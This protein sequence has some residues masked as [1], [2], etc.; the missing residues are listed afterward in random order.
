MRVVLS[1]ISKFHTFD[2]AREMDRN[3]VLVRLFTG[4][5]KWKLRGEDLPMQKVSTFPY[6]QTVW[7]ALGRFGWDRYPGK[8][9]LNWQCHK[10]LDSYVARHLPPCDVFHALSYSGL[11]SGRAAQRTGAAWV[12]DS[13]TWHWPYLED[14]M[15][16]EF[17]RVGLPYVGAQQRFVDY[18]VA[19][20][21]GA[22]AITVPSRR[23]NETFLARGVPAS[24]MAV[25]PYGADL[26][27]FAPT[28]E[29]RFDRF[30]VL[31]VGQVIV[32]KGI[33]DLLEGFR[34][35]ALPNSELLIVGPIWADGRAILARRS[36]P[37]V[38]VI[39]AVP[40][41]A[42]ADYYSSSDVMVLPS[43]CEG[44]ALVIGQALACGCP[45]IATPATGAEDLFTDAH[46]GFL[47]PERSPEAIAQALVWMYEHPDERQAMRSA[48]RARVESVAG[49]EA[50][51]SRMLEVFTALVSSRVPEALN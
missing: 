16:E 24:K 28:K 27:R 19:S 33:H 44:L 4:R 21:E 5:P 1:T 17:D 49:W 18:A 40:S 38:S 35:A 15:R 12:C 14:V 42:L 47:V 20:Y 31:F 29:P 48:A 30:R 37:G 10:T 26:S 9:W 11:R 43:I 3:N 51:G 34:L 22:D 6:F 13:P 39:G 7:E 32:R 2:L 46:E 45:V 25:V 41:T 36:Y 23:A 50:Y 8:N